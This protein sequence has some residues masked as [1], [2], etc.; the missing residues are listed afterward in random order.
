ML[1]REAADPLV[2]DRGSW[3]LCSC[4]AGR[5]LVPPLTVLLLLRAILP[6][7]SSEKR[8][9]CHNEA[10]DL[11]P[12]EPA[13]LGDI[14]SDG[15]VCYRTNRVKSVAVRCDLCLTASW[16]GKRYSVST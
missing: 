3:V 8:N 13:Q 14:G 6:R 15:Y 10:G 1:A 5:S 9:V 2:K 7:A 4:G 11:R 12:L 16:N